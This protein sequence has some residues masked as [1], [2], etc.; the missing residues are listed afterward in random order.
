MNVESL[1]HN[2]SNMPPSPYRSSQKVQGEWRGREVPSSTLLVMFSSSRSSM[3]MLFSVEFTG[4]LCLAVF[5]CRFGAAG[6][7]IF[8]FITSNRYVSVLLGDLILTFTSKDRQIIDADSFAVR[9]AEL[10]A[11]RTQQQ[12]QSRSVGLERV[13][14]DTAPSV[15]NT[16]QNKS[17]QTY[18]NAS[19]LIF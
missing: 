13:K 6:T 5:S 2:N 9:P 8:C 7:A 11:S 4:L 14:T 3:W 15:W 12:Q 19:G 17:T 18:F 1:I 10:A 16:L